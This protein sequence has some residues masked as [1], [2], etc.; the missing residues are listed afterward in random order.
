[1]DTSV[2]PLSLSASFLSVHAF[3]VPFSLKG[4]RIQDR[5]GREEEEEGSPCCLFVIAEE[6]CAGDG[7]R[8]KL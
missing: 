2:S 6:R 7:V 4:Q 8:L 1:V 3:P 5:D